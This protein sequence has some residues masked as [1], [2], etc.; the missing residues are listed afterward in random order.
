MGARLFLYAVISKTP[1][2]H[3]DT[4]KSLSWW[5]IPYTRVGAPT[6]VSLVADGIDVQLQALAAYKKAA[7]LNPD[8]KEVSDKVRA[9]NKMTRKSTGGGAKQVCFLADICTIPFGIRYS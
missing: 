4:A 9:L 8:N 3:S 2:T 6:S 1:K 5:G 7:E